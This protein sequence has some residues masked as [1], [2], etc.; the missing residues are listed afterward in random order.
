MDQLATAQNH[1][2]GHF[3]SAQATL[4]VLYLAL[5]EQINLKARNKNHVAAQWKETLNQLSLLFEDRLSIQRHQPTYT[6]SLPRP[7]WVDY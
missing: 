5:R 3:P 6:R 1:N 7:V 2:H 4:K